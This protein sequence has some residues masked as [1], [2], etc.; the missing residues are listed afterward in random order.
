[1]AGWEQVGQPWIDRHVHSMLPVAG[2]FLGARKSYRAVL[3]GICF[4]L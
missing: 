4:N 1:L 2:P 3:S